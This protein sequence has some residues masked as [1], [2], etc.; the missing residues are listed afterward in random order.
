[1][2]ASGKGGEG[3][4]HEKDRKEKVLKKGEVIFGEA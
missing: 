2:P 3:K 4:Y 1:M